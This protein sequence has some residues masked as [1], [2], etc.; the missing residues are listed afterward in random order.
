M[1]FKWFRFS[2]VLAGVLFLSFA[3]G[4]TAGAATLLVD[5][6]EG[7]EIQNRVGGRANVFQ[8][9]PSKAMISRRSDTIEG[10]TTNV[11][12]LRY[13]KHNEGGPYDMGG[14]CGYY[15]L[16]KKPG[17]LVAP[18]EGSD[19]PAAEQSPDQ[20]LDGSGYKAITF[21]VRG[22]QG[23]ENFMIGLS[24][25]HWDRVGDSVKS[26][27][28]GKYLPSGKVTKDW[29]KAVIPLDTF[30]LDYGKLGSIAFSFESDAFPD[31]K[32]AGTVYI[33]NV[34]LE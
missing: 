19:N 33:D 10:K 18:Q 1:Y 11:L 21:W 29:Q 5:D 9:A 2:F 23:G 13:E 8:K 28:V 7:E 14:W 31:G 22:E 20:Y 3:H 34:A 17:H 16:L 12:L 26:E 15:T 30:F 27:E 6:F 4:A 25:E 24:D 32:G